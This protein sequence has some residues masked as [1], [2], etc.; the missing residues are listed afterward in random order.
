MRTVTCKASD[1]D[2]VDPY[3]AQI[4]FMAVYESSC[5]LSQCSSSVLIVEDSGWMCTQYTN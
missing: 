3:R 4:I 5:H 1:V 2:A